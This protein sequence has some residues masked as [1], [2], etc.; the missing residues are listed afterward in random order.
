MNNLEQ[1]LND[2]VFLTVA[3][4]AQ[5]FGLSENTVRTKINRKKLKTVW[6]D[7]DDRNQIH[8]EVP[9]QKYRL[10]N[11]L[12]S[13]EIV[14]EVV[15]DDSEDYSEQ[16]MNSNESSGELLA[17]MRET[18][19]TVQGYSSQIVELSRENERYKLLTDGKERNVADLERLVEQLKLQNLEKD[20]KIKELESKLAQKPS[21][22]LWKGR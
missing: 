15:Q 16:A 9:H 20:A 2:P 7:K 13:S 19:Q 21:W 4:Y 1:E 22:S 8:I 12:E 6:M 10:K 18:L 17:F 5:H 3:E 14:H 11:S